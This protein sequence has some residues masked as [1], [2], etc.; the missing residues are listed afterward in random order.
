MDGVDL[1]LASPKVSSS[2]PE[3]KMKDILHDLEEIQEKLRENFTQKGALEE[4][5]Q[6]ELMLFG[7][8]GLIMEAGPVSHGFLL[9]EQDLW[10]QLRV[11]WDVNE[12]G[13]GWAIF[14][15]GCVFGP[16]WR[17]DVTQALNRQKL[18]F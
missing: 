9:R 15:A 16:D 6:G 1:S 17:C 3:Q 12:E 11:P 18:I 13:V 4:Q 8:G 10:A 5:T 14:V 7:R 2:P